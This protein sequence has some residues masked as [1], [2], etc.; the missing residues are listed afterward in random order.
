MFKV[1]LT[2]LLILSGT[3]LQ[4]MEQDISPI[5]SGEVK[6]TSHRRSK[7]VGS[8][9]ER[10]KVTANR[11]KKDT[12]VTVKNP[13]H[14]FKSDEKRGRPFSTNID[15]AQLAQEIKNHADKL[16][17]AHD[18]KPIAHSPAPSKEEIEQLVNA[19]KT[20]KIELA[21][22]LIL[23]NPAI[24]N[25]K[26]SF[27][28]DPIICIFMECYCSNF[29]RATTNNALWQ[30]ILEYGDVVD[31]KYHKKLKNIVKNHAAEFSNNNIIQI[32]C[33]TILNDI[34]RFIT[35]DKEF[36]K[37]EIENNKVFEKKQQKMNDDEQISK[38]KINFG[39]FELNQNRNNDLLQRRVSLNVKRDE[40]KGSA[41]Q[42][43]KEFLRTANEML[44]EKEK[45]F[46]NFEQNGYLLLFNFNFYKE[47]N[48]RKQISGHALE[49]LETNLRSEKYL[50]KLQNLKDR[51]L[52]AKEQEERRTIESLL[53]F[54]QEWKSLLK[55]LAQAK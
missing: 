39:L 17:K 28:S 50:K 54:Q 8:K 11:A 35:H 24:I 45:D 46:R 40:I 15:P 51:F 27:F 7:S 42:T 9:P 43:Q 3:I 13:L 48:A 44:E 36:K 38:L 49:W 33:E 18:T 30:F 16:T 31:Q 32:R 47:L 29:I 34:K 6:E 22:N 1:I 55:R 21:K 12:L 25:A 26:P 4:A 14:K 19:I 41:G 10:T 5:F 52:N 2:C 37:Q 20:C 23:L 53:K